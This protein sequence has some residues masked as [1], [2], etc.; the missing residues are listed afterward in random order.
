[1][2]LT[3]AKPGGIGSP[4]TQYSI[5]GKATKRQKLSPP[6]GTIPYGALDPLQYHTPSPVQI[7]GKDLDSLMLCSHEL[8][9]PDLATLHT[10]MLLGAWEAGLEGVSGEAATLLMLALEV[11]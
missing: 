11:C 3:D 9:L 10:R 6:M 1:M 7:M 2:F 4:H 5:S 8:M